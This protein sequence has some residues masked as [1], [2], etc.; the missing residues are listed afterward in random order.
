[1][2]FKKNYASLPDVQNDYQLQRIIND[3]Q[4]NVENSINTIDNIPIINNPIILSDVKINGATSIKHTLGRVPVGYIII[5]NSIDAIVYN[6]SMNSTN[7]V[8]NASKNTTV[9][10]YLF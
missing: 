10:I 8:L 9:S 5:K 2:P 7:I 3:V 6:V 1:M 4:T